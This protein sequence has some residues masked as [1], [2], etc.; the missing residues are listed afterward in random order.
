M[1][2]LSDTSA[3]EIERLLGEIEQDAREDLEAVGLPAAQA[4]FSASAD[5]RYQ[6]QGY[7]LSI[8]MDQLDQSDGLSLE[9]RF[10]AAH[11]R[12]FDHSHPDLADGGCHAAAT[13]DDIGAPADCKHRGSGGRAACEPCAAGRDCTCS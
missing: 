1:H 9:E 10:H 7:E 12:R 3:E 4:A 8:P 5:I 11:Q 6:G 2:D 13:R